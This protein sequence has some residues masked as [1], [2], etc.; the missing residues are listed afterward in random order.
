[1]NEEFDNELTAL[2]HKHFDDDWQF[3]W[4]GVDDGFTLN[5]V[6]WGQRDEG[7][8]AEPYDGTVDEDELEER[9]Y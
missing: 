8:G 9:K 6:V 1:M 7:D 5:L 2:L 3:S 4:E